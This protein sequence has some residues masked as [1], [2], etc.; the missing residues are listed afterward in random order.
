MRSFYISV[1]YPVESFRKRE[2]LIRARQIGARA[3][4]SEILIFLDAHSEA[5]YNWLP[6]LLEPITLD[7]K[8]VVCPFVDVIDCDTFEVRPQDEGARGEACKR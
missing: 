5:N 1:F 4:S 7:Y 8:T 3:A 6:P 2:G